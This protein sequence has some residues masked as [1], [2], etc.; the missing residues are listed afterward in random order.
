MSLPRTYAPRRALFVPEWLLRR[1]EITAGAKLAF[2]LLAWTADDDGTA[3][4]DWEA[5]GRGL[6]CRPSTA[7]GY[8]SELLTHHLVSTT[9]AR[10]GVPG[11]CRFLWHAWIEGKDR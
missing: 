7:R 5:L 10:R 3:P 4:L 1:A 6:G 11:R 9:R 8:V 2:A